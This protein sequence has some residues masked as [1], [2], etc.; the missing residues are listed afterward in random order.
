MQL[1]RGVPGKHPLE[2]THFHAGDPQYQVVQPDGRRSDA[3]IPLA[4]L[5]KQFSGDE[6]ELTG[7]MGD[8]YRISLA[9]WAAADP[10][11]TLLHLVYR[12]TPDPDSTVPA[13]PPTTPAGHPA[14][15]ARHVSL[16]GL[17]A[18]VTCSDVRREHR[19]TLHPASPGSGL[20]AHDWLNLPEAQSTVIPCPVCDATVSLSESLRVFIEE[21]VTEFDGDAPRLVLR[22]AHPGDVPE[23]KTL[24]EHSPILVDRYWRYAPTRVRRSEP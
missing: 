2:I 3:G 10:E 15:R 8:T 5:R 17:P 14:R 22:V 16:T 21:F 1:H 20:T 12:F 6:G 7:P 18:Y 23:S 4:Q 19:V 11:I 24:P 13:T 9:R